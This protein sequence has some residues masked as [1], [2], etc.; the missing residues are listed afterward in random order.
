MYLNQEKVTYFSNDLNKMLAEEE[1]KILKQK[2]KQKQKNL[3]GL[4]LSNT[5]LY[6]L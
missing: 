1:N 2:S 6:A 4:S 5:I 3:S